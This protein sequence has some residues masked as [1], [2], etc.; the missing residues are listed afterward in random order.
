[1]TETT[2]NTDGAA[3]APAVRLLDAD[4]DFARAVPERDRALADRAL[5]VRALAVDPGAAVVRDADDVIA[6]VVLEGALWREVQLGAVRAPQLLGVGAVILPEP[7]PSD[8]LELE[9]STRALTRSRVAVLDRRFILASTRW[10]QLTAILHARIAQQERDVG[11]LA[12]IGQLPR[13]E[14]RIMTLLWHLAER[15][16]TVG[17]NGVHVPLRLTHATLGRFVAA[18]RPTVSLALTELRELKMLDRE[19]DGTW[20]LHGGPPIAAA[21]DGRAGTGG[22]GSVLPQLFRRAAAGSRD[23]R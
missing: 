5:S 10:P 17:A 19:D 22:R 21:P 3:G 18:R 13:V 2:P 6:L 11:A 16:G 1:M 8:L 15:W 4:T 14:D 7:V 23:G 20:T 9:R 12:A